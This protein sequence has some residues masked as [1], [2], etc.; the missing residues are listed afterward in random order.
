MNERLKVEL[1]VNNPP[2]TLFIGLGW[3][4]TPESKTKH[5]RRFYPTELEKVTEVMSSPTPF[6][7][8]DL[9]RG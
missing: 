3:D 1:E 5:Y 9:K 4:E 2:E 8:F 6:D 7:T